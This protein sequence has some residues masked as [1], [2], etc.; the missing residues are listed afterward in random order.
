MYKYNQIADALRKEIQ[1]G[2]YK[3]GEKLPSVRQYVRDSGYNSDTVL[4]AYRLLEEEHLIYSATKSGFYVVK[5]IVPVNKKSNIDL[6]SVRPPDFINP[7]KDFYHCMEKSISL[8]QNKLFE[9]SSPQGMEELRGGLA[10]HLMNFQIFTGDKDIFITNGAQQALYILAAMTFSGKNTKVLVE[11]PTY[12]VMLK[13]LK[14]NK[15]PV[16][17]IRR[18]AEGIDL[19]ELEEIYKQGGIKFFYTMPRYQNPTGFC[20]SEEQK[21]EIIR[22]SKQYGVFIVED[23]YVADLERNERTDTLYALGDKERI[24]YIRSF[25]KTI[26]PGMRLGMTILPKVLQEE[27]LTYKQCIDLNTTVLTQGALEIYLKSSMYKSHAARTKKFY[28]GKMETLK[29]ACSQWL[30]HKV[31]CHIP[32]T[33]LYAYLELEDKAE[34]ILKALSKSG[35]LV[36]N[37]ANCFIEGF[38]HAEGIRLCICNCE[39]VDI[40]LAVK[41]IQEE[42]DKGEK[43]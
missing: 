12:S 3:P 14:C 37:T 18:T 2:H 40:E 32:P 5:S 25:S 6:V 30:N 4:K 21:R 19:E 31:I 24:I 1:E 13:V 16:F 39:D 11:Q 33:G 22:L 17:G 28:K 8:Y 20:Y 15:V 42:I 27:F 41:R 34:S 29:N 26:L 23:D 38:P 43:R 7:Y 10:K 35:V 9:Y 36:S